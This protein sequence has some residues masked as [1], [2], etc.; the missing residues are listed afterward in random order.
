MKSNKFIRNV[1]EVG[2]GNKS[3]LASAGHEDCTWADKMIQ[4][5]LPMAKEDVGCTE[6][7]YS[8]Y[9]GGLGRDNFLCILCRNKWLMPVRQD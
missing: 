5:Q 7:K 1:R 3:L 6:V 4:Q 8:T 2:R 9:L